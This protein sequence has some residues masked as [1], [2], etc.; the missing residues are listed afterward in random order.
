MS[1]FS[2]AT[3]TMD[4]G[5]LDALVDERVHY[6]VQFAAENSPFYHKWFRTNKIVPSTIR[7]HEDLR[8]LPIISGKHVRKRQLPETP[9]FEFK[10]TDLPEDL[11][12][13]DVYD[14]ALDKALS[15]P[16][17]RRNKK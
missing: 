14:P 17:L 4:R 5:E 2:E 12:H 11:V 15:R 8:D 6:T 10:C 3:E 13:L 9:E 7:E 16:S 1:Y